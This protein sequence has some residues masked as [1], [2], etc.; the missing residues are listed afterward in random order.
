[1]TKPLTWED[2]PPPLTDEQTRIIATWI[3]LSE[4]LW[5]M[6]LFETSGMVQDE[7]T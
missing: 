2:F 1:M 3:E 6:R 5:M 4:S 7:E